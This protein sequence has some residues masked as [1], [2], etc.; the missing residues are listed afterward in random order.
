[1]FLFGAHGVLVGD[2]VGVVEVSL[3]HDGRAPRPRRH[4]HAQQP[5]TATAA[6]TH[7]IIIMII[8]V[9]ILIILILILLIIII[10]IVITAIIAVAPTDSLGDER[11]GREG[12]GVLRV[13]E[14]I[15]PLWRHTD[16]RTTGITDGRTPGMS[17]H[18]RGEAPG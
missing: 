9:V 10:I 11:G 3:A 1:M 2:E 15:Q 14:P 8:V 13:D 18:T 4:R 7:I 17:G 6:I 16:G 12:A 5:A